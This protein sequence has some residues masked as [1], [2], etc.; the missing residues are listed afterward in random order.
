MQV[1]YYILFCPINK[2]NALKENT[3]VYILKSKLDLIKISIRL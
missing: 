2:V 3:Y 1:N